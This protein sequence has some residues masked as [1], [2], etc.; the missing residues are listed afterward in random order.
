MLTKVTCW[1]GPTPV[2]SPGVL[3]VWGLEVGTAGPCSREHLE[4]SGMTPW[5][6]NGVFEV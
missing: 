6:R 4:D 3:K 1:L 2:Q 5:T